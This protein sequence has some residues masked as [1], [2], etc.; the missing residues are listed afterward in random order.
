MYIILYHFCSFCSKKLGTFE[1]EN[2]L[3]HKHAEA[4]LKKVRDHRKKSAYSVADC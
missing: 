2:R 1:A 3:F 4:K